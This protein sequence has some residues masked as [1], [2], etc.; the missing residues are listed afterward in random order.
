MNWIKPDWPLPAAVRAVTTLRTGGVS[1]DAYAS[2]NPAGHVNDDP[3]HVQTNRQRIREMLQLPS[4]PVWLQQVHGVRVVKADQAGGLEE[5][6]ASY[7]DQAGIVC[8][9]LTADCLPILLCG[10]KGDV[11]AAAHAGWRGLLAGVIRQTLAAMNCRDISV[12]LG[13]AIGPESFEVG[14]DVR[15]AFVQANSKAEEAFKASPSGKWLADIYRLAR[16]ALAEEGIDRIHG[17]NYCTVN[18]SQRFY[19]Y[20]RDGAATG[21]MASLIWRD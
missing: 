15:T 3:A 11:I 4:E 16:I 2:L 21:R 12:W 10:D 18:D 5:A 19:S 17:G 1:L 20:R 13:P 6:D 14:D 7:T 8:A 9:V